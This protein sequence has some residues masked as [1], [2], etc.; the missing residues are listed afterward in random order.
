[1]SKILILD[2]E[3]QNIEYIRGLL[4]GENFEVGFL[5]KAEFLFMRLQVDLPD[6]VLLD[7]NMPGKDGIS[8]LKEMKD[9][10]VYQDIPVIMITGETN[11]QTLAHCFKLGAIDYITKPFKKLILIS[12]IR[13]AI[14][15]RLDREKVKESNRK[16][17]FLNEKL[18]EKVVER[19]QALHQEMTTDRLTGLFNRY[20][21][22]SIMSNQQV[23]LILINVNEFSAINN[24]YGID[25]GNQ[26][27]VELAERLISIVENQDNLFRIGVDEFVILVENEEF[28]NRL[29]I[30]IH[31]VLSIE[32]YSYKDANFFIQVSVGVVVGEVE[33]HLQ[34]ADISRRQSK[35]MRR[36]VVHI[37]KKD[38]DEEA[39]YQTNLNWTKKVK[40]GLENDQ[41][42]A[43]YQGIR[44]N[45][46]G[47]IS[48]Y[49]TLVRLV[50]EDGVISPYFFLDS[51]KKAGLMVDTT[52]SLL[53][54]SL[55]LFKHN[56]NDFSL[57]LTEDEIKEPRFLDVLLGMIESFKFD[58]KR[59]TFEILE[60]MSLE[61]DA[62]SL[63]FFNQLKTYGF[64]LAIDDF[65]TGYSNFS[66][67]FDLNVD[68][69]K[70][71]GSFI[72]DIHQNKNSLKITKIIVD[73]SSSIDAEIVAE[74]VH[75]EEVQK[76]V[77]DLGIHFSQ[78]FLYSEPKPV[79]L[80]SV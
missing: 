4:E 12:R 7:I 14:G 54:Q 62:E 46:T 50:N 19:T 51:T 18:E 8:L 10:L 80:D 26:I 45:R 40:M 22:E 76:I 61:N 41:M 59:I 32:P 78:G 57:N 70:I 64:K 24:A 2:D 31:N 55:E 79:L 5:T 56:N 44:D 42:R 33:N 29:C 53:K 9:H 48:K 38:N 16:L 68:Y 20:K 69:I 47:L 71:D 11:E 60:A 17:K 73:L 66:R 67:L 30:D 75:C 34:K 13:N 58:P 39:R 6:L 27:L 65:G 63:R 15:A 74:Y 49:E 3:I 21:L 77:E 37:Y 28:I 23:N 35:T 1:M 36:G 52:I 43:F 72:K 25:A